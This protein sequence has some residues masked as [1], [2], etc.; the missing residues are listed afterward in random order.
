MRRSHQ[1]TDP[2]RVRHDVPSPRKTDD[3]AT[4]PG[5][6]EQMPSEVAHR[7]VVAVRQLQRQHRLPEERGSMPRPPR[8]P[9]FRLPRGTARTE[10]KVPV[11]R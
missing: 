10:K 5:E 6:L 11:P 8:T 9:V 7:R 3:V 1:R 4:V 2:R